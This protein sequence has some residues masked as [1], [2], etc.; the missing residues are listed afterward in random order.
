[1]MFKLLL[2]LPQRDHRLSDHNSM[3]DGFNVIT[4]VKCGFW[5]FVAGERWRDGSHIFWWDLA[6]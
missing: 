5:G 3:T 2:S 4:S 6:F 1:M